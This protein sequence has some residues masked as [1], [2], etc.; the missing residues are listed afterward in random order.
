[1]KDATTSDVLPIAEIRETHPVTVRGSSGFLSLF[2]FSASFQPDR[3]CA[4][5][6]PQST[7]KPNWVNALGCEFIQME[8]NSSKNDVLFKQTSSF[9]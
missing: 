2:L 7:H 9:T 4:Q 1:M 8:D 3:V 5:F 6:D